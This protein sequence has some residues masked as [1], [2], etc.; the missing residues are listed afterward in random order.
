MAKSSLALVFGCFAL[1]SGCVAGDWA[2]SYTDAV[3][4]PATSWRVAEID[5]QVPET[6]TVSEENSLAPDADIVWREE[7]AG[8]RYAQ[9]DTII[10]EAAER[11]SA[12]L[13]G[14]RPV[15]LVLVVNAFHALSERA[16][17]QLK[18]SGVHH[19]GFSAQIFDIQSGQPLTVADPILADIEAYVGAQA[20]EAEENGMTQRVRIVDHVSSV[21]AGWLGTGED[22]RRTF[23]RRGR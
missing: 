13:S 15:R 23:S 12:G 6:L 14:N 11:G 2:T 5:V 8:D 9:V 21:I 7:E 3:A 10:T 1:L 16:R 18:D 4:D 20:L 19:I 17:T 22:V